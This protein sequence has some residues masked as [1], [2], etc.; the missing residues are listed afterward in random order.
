MPLWQNGRRAFGSGALLLLGGLG[1]C[2]GTDPSDVTV[3]LSTTAV[4]FEAVG[5][6]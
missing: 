5:E 3:T 1:G 2:Q 4:S 6:T